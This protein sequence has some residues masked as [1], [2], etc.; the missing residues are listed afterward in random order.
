MK[1]VQIL[2]CLL[3]VSE[4]HLS[5]G[6]GFYAHRRINRLAVFTLP[7]E[8]MPFFKKHLPT[9]TENAVNPD[10]RRYAVVG[11]AARHYIDLEAYGDSVWAKPYWADAV[12]YYSEDTLMAHGIAPWHIQRMK[13]QLTDAFRE[14]NVRAILRLS[15]DLGHYLADVHVPLH[16]TR[17]YNGQLTGQDGLH[18]FWETRLP[19]LY[20]EGYDFFVG[21]AAYV[22]SPQRRVWAAVRGAHACLDSIFRYEKELTAEWGESR[23]YVIEERNGGTGQNLRPCVFGAVP[24]PAR[25]AGGAADAGV[26]QGHR[27]FLV[28]VLGRCRAAGYDRTG[29]HGALGPG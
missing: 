12:A 27:R 29:A 19:E 22:E 24:R 3:L 4:P 5:H 8:M 7:P 23:E 11:E 13:Y 18:A 2:L 20:A 16:T 17:N 26:D 15:A 6:W 28:H 25:P 21:P 10:R 1:H 9:L 14:K